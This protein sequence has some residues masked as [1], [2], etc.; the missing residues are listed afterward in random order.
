MCRGM[1]RQLVG[2]CSRLPRYCGKPTTTGD[3]FPQLISCGGEIYS[4]LKLQCS[5]P[6]TGKEN[7]P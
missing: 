5:R 1:L 2:L 4:E 7:W 3:F 6:N